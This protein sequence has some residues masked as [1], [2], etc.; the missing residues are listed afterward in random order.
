MKLATSPHP[1][2]EKKQKKLIVIKQ[3]S[4]LKHYLQKAMDLKL[5]TRKIN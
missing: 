3:W 5:M 2:P 4:V 1:T